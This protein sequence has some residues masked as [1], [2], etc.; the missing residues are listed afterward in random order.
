MLGVAQLYNI[1][2]IGRYVPYL[3]RFQ[4]KKLQ[5]DCLTSMCLIFLQGNHTS[6]DFSHQQNQKILKSRTKITEVKEQQQKKGRLQNTTSHM[7]LF[8]STDTNLWPS[9]W[10]GRHGFNSCIELKLISAQR[11]FC[12]ALSQSVHWQERFYIAVLSIFCILSMAI[13]LWQSC[14]S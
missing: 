12:V 13:L 7:L 5:M 6:I 14:K 2:D 3:Q 11:P 9:S 4:L 1:S 8:L 10:V